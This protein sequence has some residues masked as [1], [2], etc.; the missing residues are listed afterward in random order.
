MLSVT[1]AINFIYQNGASIEPLENCCRTIKKLLED[2]LYVTERDND[3]LV[4]LALYYKINEED[5]KNLPNVY[6]NWRM[7]PNRSEG[8]IAYIDT[9]VIKDNHKGVLRKMWN[10]GVSGEKKVKFLLWYDL[11]RNSWHLSKR[12]KL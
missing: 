3:E 2:N 5:I 10:I 8:E 11:G 7:L 9:L 4:G 6:L 12:R 1:E